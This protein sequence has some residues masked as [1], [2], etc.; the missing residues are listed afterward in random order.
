MFFLQKMPIEHYFQVVQMISKNIRSKRGRKNNKNN[1]QTIH[2]NSWIDNIN[3][4]Y[5]LTMKL[6]TLMGSVLAPMM[7]N[8]KF[9]HPAP[10]DRFPCTWTGRSRWHGANAPFPDVGAQCCWWNGNDFWVKQISSHSKFLLMV[11][12]VNPLRLPRDM[13]HSLRWK[14]WQT[15]MTN[16]NNKLS[17]SMQHKRCHRHHPFHHL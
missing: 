4:I 12:A 3:C 14:T 11:P 1:L 15:H 17:D 2:N 10:L 13:R 16:R 5:I 8:K 9:T 6:M 7:K